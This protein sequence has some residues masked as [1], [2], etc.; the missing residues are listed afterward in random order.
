MNMP[1]LFPNNNSALDFLKGF[2]HHTANGFVVLW[3]KVSKTE[4]E[5]HSFPVTDL[6]GAAAKL[7]ELALRGDTYV[8][9]GLQGERPGRGERG[10]SETV[11]YVSGIFAD[12]DTREGPHGSPKN[13]T[14]PLTLPAN[15]EEAMELVREAGLPEPTIIIHTGGG[16]HLHWTYTAPVFLK[17]KAERVAET[18]LA[19]AWLDRLRAV[20]KTRGYKL[21]GVADLARVCKAPGTWNHKT[22]PAGPA[23][24]VTL[25]SDTGPQ[26]ERADALALVATNMKAA[27]KVGSKEGTASALLIDRAMKA[28]IAKAKPDNLASV[29][30]GCAWMEHCEADAANLPEPEWH[31]MLGISGRCE[32]GRELSHKLSEPYAGYSY[33]ETE[34]KID[35][36][37]NDA[38]PVTCNKVAGEFGFEGCTRCPFSIT[39]PINL[40]NQPRA[41]VK[42]QRKTVFI[43]KGRV[44]YDLASGEKLD[45]QEFGD[46]V[47]AKVGPM[48]HDKLTGSPT[49][50]IVAR[51]E[52]LPGNPNLILHQADGT[53]AVNMWQVAGVIPVKG[54]ASPILDYFDRLIPIPTD[55]R[56]LIQYLAHLYRY[57]EVKI[58]FG[59]IITGG[60]GTGKS[61]YHRLV[62]GLFGPT[63]AR[64]LEGAELASPYN[65]RWVD[66]QV[67]MIEEAHH[68]ERLEVFK[69]TLELL[70]AEQINVHDK[71]VR[72]FQGRTPR[73]ITMVSNDEAPIVL[74]PG[75]RRWFVT[76]TLP[77]PETEEENREHRTFFKRLYEV[78]DRDDTALAAFAYHLK[79]EV[80]LKG[81]EPKG[82]PLMTAAKET[83]TKASRTPMAQVLVELIESG[84][85]PFHKDIVEVKEVIHALKMSDYAHTVERITPQKVAAVLH[86]VRAKQLNMMDGKHLELAISRHVKPRPWAIRDTSRWLTETREAMK[87]EYLRIPG[88]AGDN[89]EPFQEAA[90]KRLMEKAAKAS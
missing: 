6:E 83:A 43:Q 82:T 39:S 41:L 44:Y 29:L 73:G 40:A 30:A 90:L 1:I 37:L 46:G 33:Q 36:A 78:L 74:P 14:D 58:E 75:D 32:D 10:K 65:A 2:F 7:A 54:D 86:S 3:L 12:I 56:F 89:V 76:A 35:H 24:P 84:K 38:G 79:H 22:C 5:T 70:V 18:A 26:I 51:R 81:F 85:A 55:R 68:G 13:P 72:Q 42:A 71:Y 88:D 25:V 31:A 53:K 49:M 34:D 15:Q 4:S 50:P 48:P 9:R 19:E 57:Q 80:D 45:P 62:K 8:G 28:A 23:K 16:V 47:R 87:A 52:Y 59:A 66:C 17:T 27:T 69:A 63:N 21:D 61:T 64:K 60:F 77:T 67:L 20:F 11:V